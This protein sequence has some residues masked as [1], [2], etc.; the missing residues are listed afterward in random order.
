VLFSQGRKKKGG[1][2]KALAGLDARRLASAGGLRVA[3]NRVRFKK[4]RASTGYQ[5]WS[6]A[7]PHRERWWEEKSLSGHGVTFFKTQGDTSPRL[8]GKLLNAAASA[9]KGEA[10]QKKRRRNGRGKNTSALN[11]GIRV[12]KEGSLPLKGQA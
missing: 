6:L 9:G 11:K 8:S 10:V 2:G 5:S 7:S 4:N 12:K 1:G 3:K